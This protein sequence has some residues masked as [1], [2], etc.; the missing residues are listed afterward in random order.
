[1]LTETELEELI[2]EV[3][4]IL[5]EDLAYEG[6]YT[7]TIKTFK[8]TGLSAKHGLIIPFEDGSEFQVTIV[9]SQ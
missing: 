3:L 4:E 5:Q 2:Q 8:Q 1:M 7:D 6:P 9:R